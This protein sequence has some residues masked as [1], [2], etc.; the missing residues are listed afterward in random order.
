[1]TAAEVLARVRVAGGD[2]VLVDGAPRL[3]APA[4]LPGGLVDLA[5]SFRAELVVL[6]T[7][8]PETPCSHLDAQ[9]DLVV[10]FG[11]SPEALW[12]MPEGQS[13]LTRLLNLE[14]V[15]EV[16][17]RYLDLTRLDWLEERAAILEYDGNMSRAEAERAAIRELAEREDRR[18]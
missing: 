17:R 11:S 3:R 14:A 8:G 6:L 4:P 7:S 5:R 16:V 15:P 2:V 12:W 18:H 13:I 10:P 9:G 1:M